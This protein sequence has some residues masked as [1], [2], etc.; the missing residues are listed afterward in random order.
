MLKTS[1]IFELYNCTG[2][3]SL[4]RALRLREGLALEGGIASLATAS[5][6]LGAID[7]ED[8][9]NAFMQWMTEILRTRGAYHHRWKGTLGS[10]RTDKGSKHSI[11]ILNAI[12]AA[13][14]LVVCQLAITE[15]ENEAAAIPKLLEMLSMK[16]S[17]VTIDAIGTTTD[18]IRKITEKGAH[19]LLTVKLNQPT[20]Y[21]EIMQYFAEHTI[22]EENHYSTKE[23]NRERMEYRDIKCSQYV[24][25]ISLSDRFPNVK[26]FAV[27]EQVRIRREKDNAGNDITP[28]KETYLKRGTVRRPKVTVG[29]QLTDDVYRI[30]LVTDQELSPREM[31]EM[32][33]NHWKIENGLHHVLDDTLHEDRSPARKSKNNLSLLRK[34][35][36]NIQQIAR[37]QE[38]YPYGFPEMMDDFADDANK[39][40]HYILQ[41]I[42]SFY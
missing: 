7:E 36:F 38:N 17:V 37:I 16:D 23:K 35:V 22:T 19:Y 13:T 20:T 31:L 5:R 1:A 12:E 40:K 9:C 42:Q 34:F 28:D 27:V 8:F 39:N 32:K 2:R 30:G 41:G 15:R 33:R 24:E 6:M 21:Y 29:D 14:N 26:Q 11:Y 25:W 3:P 18:I 10:N 4:R